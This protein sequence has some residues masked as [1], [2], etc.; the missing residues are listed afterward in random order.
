MHALDRIAE[1]SGR[2]VARLRTLGRL[3]SHAT[4]PRG[5]T[6]VPA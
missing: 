4:D 1:P 2:A 5:L 6:D 3:R